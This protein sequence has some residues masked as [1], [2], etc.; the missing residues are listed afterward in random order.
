[1]NNDSKKENEKAAQDH[2]ANA[3][4]NVLF[5]ELINSLVHEQPTEPIPYMV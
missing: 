2:M 5:K 1:M 4:L 3:K